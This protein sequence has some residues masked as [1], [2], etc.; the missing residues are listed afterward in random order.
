MQYSQSHPANVVLALCGDGLVN[1]F[2]AADTQKH[3][4]HF[5]YKSLQ[6]QI[7]WLVNRV[8]V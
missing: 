4:L 1:N 5:V 7:G 8:N 2:L 3:F 6:E